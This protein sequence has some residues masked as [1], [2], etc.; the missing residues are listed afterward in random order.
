MGKYESIVNAYL[1]SIGQPASIVMPKNRY[2]TYPQN[3][4]NLNPNLSNADR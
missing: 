1:T 4:V 3:Q 2:F